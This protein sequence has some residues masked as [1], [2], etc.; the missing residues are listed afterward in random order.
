MPAID[1]LFTISGPASRNSRRTSSTHDLLDAKVV[2]PFP[3]AVRGGWCF[4]PERLTAVAGGAATG[5]P[6]CGLPQ[7]ILQP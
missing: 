6:Q 3:V 7:G 4:V 2:M 1:R 5:G